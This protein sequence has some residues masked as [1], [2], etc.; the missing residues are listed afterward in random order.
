MALIPCRECGKEISSEAAK[1]PHCGA[2]KAPNV[3]ARVFG[4]ASLFAVLLT[5]VAWWAMFRP[6]PEQRYQDCVTHNLALEYEH[7][8]QKQCDAP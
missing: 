3:G 7:R 8:P 1:C 5:V 6:S 2:R 4:F